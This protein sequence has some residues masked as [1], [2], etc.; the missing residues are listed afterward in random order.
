M[1]RAERFTVAKVERLRDV[2]TAAGFLAALDLANKSRTAA[3]LDAAPPRAI[4]RPRK[5]TAKI[6]GEFLNIL[7]EGIRNVFRSV[8]RGLLSDRNVMRMVLP[9]RRR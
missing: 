8:V 1:R 6:E 4:D 7:S 5:L 9:N 3:S 2:A